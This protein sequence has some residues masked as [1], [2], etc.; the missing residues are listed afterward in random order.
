M[1]NLIDPSEALE[2]GLQQ[3]G[4][5]ISVYTLLDYL[6]ILQKWNRIYNLTSI[7]DLPTMVTK[8][9]LDSLAISPWLQGERLLDVGTGAGFPGIPLALAHPQL[10]IT[11]LDSNGKKTRFLQEVKRILHL[12]NVEIVNSR[13]EAYTP[14][15]PFDMILSRAFTELSQ[16]ILWTKHLLKPSSGQWLAMKGHRPEVELNA[17]H[18]SYTLHFYQVP[19]LE[20][21]RCC[22]IINNLG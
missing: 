9:L 3:L 22:I 2:Q 14:S 20:E 17:L 5:D 13:A 15:L 8:H 6:K 7:R 1:N 11:L 4:L 10:H 16:F 18:N 21:E 19:G 12:N